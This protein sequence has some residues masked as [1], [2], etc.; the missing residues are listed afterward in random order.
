MIFVVNCI[1]FPIST[2]KDF[3]WISFPFFLILPGTI[4]NSYSCKHHELNS[5]C[6]IS[7]FKVSS[8]NANISKNKK[9]RSSPKQSSEQARIQKGE[10]ELWVTRE[11]LPT[12]PT[13]HQARSASLL[14]IFAILFAIFVTSNVVLLLLSKISTFPQDWTNLVL[15]LD[16]EVS[17]AINSQPFKFV[18]ALLLDP[19]N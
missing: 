2:I 14:E 5:G 16:P 13:L 18:R 11:S 7:S 8:N 15:F 10:G 17:W 3:C 12:N 19:W 9:I 4:K 6:Y 1:F